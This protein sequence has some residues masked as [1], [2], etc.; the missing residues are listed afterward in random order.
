[1]RAIVC[2]LNVVFVSVAKEESGLI[3]TCGIKIRDLM[4]RRQEC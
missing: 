1:M 2:C 4:I 3:G